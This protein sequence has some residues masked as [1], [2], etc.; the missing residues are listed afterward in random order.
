MS[1]EELK[2]QGWEVGGVCLGTAWEAERLGQIRA[3]MGDVARGREPARALAGIRCS[4]N[5]P[6]GLGE[7]R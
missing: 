3:Q 7:S 5:L 1:R 4:L 2:A 6:R